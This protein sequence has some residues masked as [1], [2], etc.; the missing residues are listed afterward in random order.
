MA[1]INK[2]TLAV[3]HNIDDLVDFIALNRLEPENKGLT[4]SDEFKELPESIAD[5]IH[6]LD[7]E[8][9]FNSAGLFNLFANFSKDRL[10]EIIKSLEKTDNGNI[11]AILEQAN[12]IVA[13]HNV[14]QEQ[15]H[16][17]LL[18]IAESQED[19]PEEIYPELQAA[20]NEVEETL[21]NLLEETDYWEKAKATVKL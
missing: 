21:Y 6:I 20:L 16:N 3:F 5:I 2:E 19:E 10:N 15:L 12:Q 18:K 17:E 11:A 1:K 4:Q 13:S 9:V 8:I 7:F 14:N